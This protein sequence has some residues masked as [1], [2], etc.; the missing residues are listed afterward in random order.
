VIILVM[1]L[2]GRTLPERGAILK[3]RL[4]EAPEPRHVAAFGGVLIP[5]VAAGLIFFPFNLRLGLVNSLSGAVLALSFVV[6]VGL[7]GQISLMQVTFAGLAGLVMT[8]VS[9]Q[10]GVP[11]PFDGIIAM[12][13]AGVVGVVVG[14]PAIRIRGVQL[15]VLTLGVAFAFENMVFD[16]PHYLTP[17]DESQ[18]V[19]A[20]SLF[21]FHFN[22]NGSFPFGAHGAPNATFGLFELGVVVLAFLFVIRLRRSDFGRQFLAVRGNERAA[23]ATGINVMA[24]KLAAFGICACL[25]GLSGVL[26]AYQFTAIQ[27][28]PY[29]ALASISALAFAYLGGI[30]SISGAIMAGSLIAGGFTFALLQQWFHLGQFQALVGGVGVIITVVTQPEGIAG[31]NRVLVRRAIAYLQ[32]RSAS[33][34]SV[35]HDITSAAGVAGDDRTRQA[36]TKLVLPAPGSSQ[37]GP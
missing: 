3:V 26:Q 27:P 14:S 8:G 28:E 30:S 12:L 4:P 18:S 15:A 6:V 19:R 5:L 35:D 24:T 1:I 29:I 37:P 22:V 2:R 31:F 16:N 33:R 36:A 23:A 20:P 9:G 32:A 13:V 25:A 17:T 7:A 34:P 10:W 11:F 21:G